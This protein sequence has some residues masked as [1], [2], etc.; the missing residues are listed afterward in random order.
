M[1][2][3]VF[4]QMYDGTLCT[5]G[6]WEALVTFQQLLVLSDQ[7]GN[8][9]MT[10]EAIS[11]RT[12][13][14]LEIIKKGLEVLMLPD[15]ESRTPTD[16]GRRIV[17]LAE[18]RAWGWKIVNYLLYRGLKR[19][20]DRRDYHRAYW[21]EKRSPKVQKRKTQKPQQSSTASTKS[22]EAEAEAEEKKRIGAGAPDKKTQ[23]NG[24]DP[25]TIELP[26]WLP[27][28]IWALWAEHRKQIR[29][30]L[31]AISCDQQLNDL[32]EWRKEGLDPAAII[33]SSISAGWQGLFKPKT[34]N[35][36]A[37]PP[38]APQQQTGEMSEDEYNAYL[39]AAG[40]IP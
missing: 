37:G 27:R 19:E 4:S 38:H 21:H 26:K 40:A 34:G 8:V 20:E 24:F 6:P 31:T 11:R 9:D 13:I 15:D 30:A 18:G 5:R 2:A 39:R 22:T 36:S 23:Q 32:N 35:G 12:T 33:R 17:P 14:P 16:E 29:K 25:K 7:E 10:A 1:Y 3:K 28:E